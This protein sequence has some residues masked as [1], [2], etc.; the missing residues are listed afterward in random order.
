MTV[1]PNINIQIVF[2]DKKIPVVV[3]RGVH[4]QGNVYFNDD[5]LFLCALSIWSFISVVGI[6]EGVPGI[7]PWVSSD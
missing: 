4:H 7:K 6:N 3:I 1:C 2:T 5:F